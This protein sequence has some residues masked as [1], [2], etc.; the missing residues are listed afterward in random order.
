MHIKITQT[1]T[2]S[3]RVVA[4]ETG[5]ISIGIAVGFIVFWPMFFGIGFLDIYLKKKADEDLQQ[6]MKEAKQ[7]EK[8]KKMGQMMVK[9]K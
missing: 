4:D 2:C 8:R 3:C 6:K 7:R 1:H 5:I 9:K